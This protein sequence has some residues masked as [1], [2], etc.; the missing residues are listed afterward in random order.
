MKK[1]MITLFSIISLTSFSINEVKEEYGMTGIEIS[2]SI[3]YSS[4][5]SYN[6]E[7]KNLDEKYFVIDTINSNLYEKL[8]LDN[9][10]KDNVYNLSIGRIVDDTGFT[11]YNYDL[12]LGTN[13]DE[14]W[15]VGINISYADLRN[16]TG[17]L[18]QGNI[19]SKWSN[20]E[21]TTF[22]SSIYGGTYK[23]KDQSS[24][25]YFGITN[26]YEKEYLD[27]DEVT[28]S[29]YVQFDYGSIEDNQSLYTEIGFGIEKIIY[30]GWSDFDRF[31][32]PKVTFGA[33][34]EFLDGDKYKDLGKDEFATKIFAKVEIPMKI[35]TFEVN[36]MS[37]FSK[38]IVDSNFE[39]RV[40]INFKYSF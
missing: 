8:K 2:S 12:L 10:D 35:N 11:A 19:F 27:F 29:P 21:D 4:K 9:Y 39:T 3:N 32:T 24:N 34:H 15:R 13:I 14:F 6:S 28:Y 36:P 25:S 5:N 26:K 40:G 22:I 38:S 18:F 30:E 20:G 16:T 37:S 7:Q 31:V 23:E 17:D 33:G 1:L